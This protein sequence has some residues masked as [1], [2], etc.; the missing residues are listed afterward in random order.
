M[1][2]G[3]LA[4]VGGQLVLLGAGAMRGRYGWDKW[5][6]LLLVCGVVLLGAGALLIASA[7]LLGVVLVLAGAVGEWEWQHQLKELAPRGMGY[8]E[9]RTPVAQAPQPAGPVWHR[10]IVVNRQLWTEEELAY[11]DRVRFVDLALQHGTSQR[12]LTGLSLRAG[13]T[14]SQ[15]MWDEMCKEL[16]E[17][18]AATRDGRGNLKWA[19]ERDGKPDRDGILDALGIPAKYRG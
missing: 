10:P 15:R 5:D 14:I 12:N 16:A 3:R 17:V 1:I 11:R 8:E 4:Q 7:Y 19:V 18:G 6:T 9:Q 13:T 2:A